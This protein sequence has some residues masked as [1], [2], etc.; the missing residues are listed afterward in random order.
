MSAVLIHVQSDKDEAIAEWLIDNPALSPDETLCWHPLE[1][2][3]AGKMF[4]DVLVRRFN[5]ALA[6]AVT[7]DTNSAALAKLGRVVV[8]LA[9]EAMEDVAMEKIH[10][11]RR[12]Y[13]QDADRNT[14]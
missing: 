7:D 6:D 11:E 12:S 9:R 13:A 3:K 4:Q 5:A 2:D 10:N 1:G 8:A 14:Q